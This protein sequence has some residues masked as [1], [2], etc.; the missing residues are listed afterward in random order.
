MILARSQEGKFLDFHMCPQKE[1]VVYHDGKK[2]LG[3]W[4]VKQSRADKEFNQPVP[5]CS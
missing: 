4:A 3:F 2:I 1:T 5:S